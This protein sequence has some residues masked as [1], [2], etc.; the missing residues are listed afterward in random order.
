MLQASIFE[1]NALFTSRE[2]RSLVG[3]PSQSNIPLNK[4]HRSPIWRDRNYSER[5]ITLIYRTGYRRYLPE[6]RQW[7]YS[8]V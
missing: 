4:R 7:E 2:R 5:W 3:R 6:L 1:V 8:K